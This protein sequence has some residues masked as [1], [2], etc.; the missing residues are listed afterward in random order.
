MNRNINRRGE[1]R[2]MDLLIA[3]GTDD[4]ENLTNGHAGD[5]KYFY[6]Y[7]FSN[8]KEELVERRRNIELGAGQSLK[9]GSPEMAKARAVV[10]KNLDALVGKEFGPGLPNLLKQFVCILVRI[11]TISKAIEVVR[12]NLDKIRQERDKGEDRKHIVLRA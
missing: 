8:S 6:L 4:G 9:P 12:N 11:N 1:D 2:G 3:F 7:K 10:F 5:A